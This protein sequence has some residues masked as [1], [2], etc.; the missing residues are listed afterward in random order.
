M[1]R[2][3]ALTGAVLAFTAPEAPAAATRAEYAAESNAIC[4]ET[5]GAIKRVS[6]SFAAQA[7]KI[8]SGEPVKPKQ[9][10]RIIRS[11]S[12]L[13]KRTAAIEATEFTRLI[14]VPA[15]PGDELL[16]SQWLTSHND[17]RKLN[18]RISELLVR[19]FK[20]IPIEPD[21]PEP[22]EAESKF[23]KKAATVFTK[24]FVLFSA[25]EEFMQKDYDLG[26]QLG[27]NRCVTK[28]PK[29]IFASGST[30]AAAARIAAG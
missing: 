6:K 13:T 23:P 17:L 16:V 30:A 22:G 20:V 11:L 18:K 19:L 3:V 8:G 5:N 4:V 29:S 9:R 15:A 26:N 10:A 24:L 12:R 28:P 2:A 25:S 21:V 14:P 1:G 27:V 7:K